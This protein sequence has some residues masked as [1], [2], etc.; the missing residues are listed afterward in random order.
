MNEATTTNQTWPQNCALACVVG[1]AYFLAACLSLN[2][3]QGAGGIATIWPA[4][5]IFV[6]TL[7]LAR[8]GLCGP[9]ICA[10]GLASFTSNLVFDASPGMALAFTFANIIEGL[11]ISQLVIRT[12]GLPRMLDDTRWLATFFIATIVGST[13]SGVIATGLVGE[14]ALP[15][16]ISW[17]TTVCLGTLIVTP[18]IVTIVNGLQVK[19]LNAARRPIMNVFLLV[20]CLATIS[21]L[22]LSN[23]DG[24]LL[25]IPVIGVITATYF[26][27][28]RGAAVSISLISIIATVQ[29]DFSKPVAGAFGLDGDTLFLQFYLLSLLCAA[30]PLSLLMAE[31]AKLIDQYAETNTFLKMAESAAQV[32]HWCLGKDNS[33]LLWSDEVYRIHGVE[34]TDLPVDDTLDIKETSSLKLYHPDDRATVRATLLSAMERQE[35]FAY[36][37]RIVRPDGSIRYISSIGRPQYDTCG[38]FEGVF[39]TLQD[40]TEQTETLEALRIA[41]TDALNQAAAAQRLAE[42]DELTGI[43]NRRKAFTMLRAAAHS[44]KRSQKP[45]TIAIFDIDHFKSVNDRFGH[46]VGDEVLKRIA[47]IVSDQ[48][49]P[50]DLVGRLGGEEFLVILPGEDERIG[51]KI[52]ERLRLLIASERWSK[53]GLTKVTVSAGLATLSDSG[54]IE[55][56]LQRADEALYNAKRAGRNL[57]RSA[58]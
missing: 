33:S 43:A 52:I 16:F 18:F 46:H 58:A 26:F 42:T 24:R 12:S 41:R 53:A 50:T 36:E 1:V 44:S 55:D 27:G 34:P 10:V 14:P 57:L 8:P 54:D 6:S 48:M 25:F 17:V 20:F 32:G 35:G 30:W 29:T 2:L 11:V 15:F 39:G 47:E 9:L 45:L 23:E 49:R 38:D 31:K 37:A 19:P 28:T 3:T 56:A 22:A 21:S 7:L 51:Y 13:I 4:S 5:G 40:I